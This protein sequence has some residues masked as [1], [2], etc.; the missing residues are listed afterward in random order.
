MGTVSFRQNDC[1]EVT[2]S[3]RYFHG[4]NKGLLVGGYIL[5]PAKTGARSTSDLVDTAG[6]HRRDR[7][8][9]TTVFADAQAFE[10]P[11]R[12][13]VVYEVE[14]QGTLEDDPDVKQLGRSYACEQAKIVSIHEV[15]G[16]VIKKLRQAALNRGR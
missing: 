15:P 1:G 11:S 2:M 13:P 10:S 16:K 8:Y 9:V 7:V 5:P 6:N 3:T 12:K 14:P 4:G